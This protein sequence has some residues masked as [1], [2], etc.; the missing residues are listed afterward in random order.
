[1]EMKMMTPR[2]LGIPE[3]FPLP[4]RRDW[5]IG[6]VGFG[7]IARHAHVPALRELG[8]TPVAVADPDPE[9]RR[10]ARD[11]FGIQRVYEAYEDLIADDAVEVVEL[12]TQPILR[13]PV[14]RRAVEA[15]K[16]LLTEKPL[17][18][19]L[20][21][22]ERI[23]HLAQQAGVPV[24]VNQNYRWMTANFL[25][26]Q[27]IHGGWIGEPYFAAITMYGR[28]EIDLSHHAFY[29]G[30]DDFLPLQWDVHFV[31]L[32]RDWTGHDAR[33]VFATT[34][35]MKGQRFKSDLLL[36]VVTDFGEGLTG[37]VVHHELTRGR[38]SEVYCRVDGDAGTLSFDFWAGTVRMESNRLGDG[39]VHLD[40]SGCAY[41]GSFAGSIAD[42]LLAVE[43][44]AEPTVSVQ[45]NLATMRTVIAERDSARA[46]GAWTP[47]IG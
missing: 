27:L 19:D 21:E 5:R 25:A 9:M 29:V 46:G 6:L 38:Q 36:S 33:R 1:M 22:C 2:D 43:T 24:A 35:R 20:S 11:E 10:L 45:R 32:M 41:P 40:L 44:G 17:A 14:I 23:A 42:F 37:Q 4:A 12:L 26:R 39:M 15:G 31:D 16:P 7:G 47:V 3:A 8:I 13:E 34:G 30:F 28:Q 18:M